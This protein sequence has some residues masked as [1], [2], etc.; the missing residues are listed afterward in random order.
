[1]YQ[2]QPRAWMTASLFT[3]WYDEVFIP[4]VKKHQNASGTKGDVFLLVDNAP[5]HPSVETMPDLK[6]FFS[7]T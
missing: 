6:F 1:M 3:E 5:T 4:A 7:A 2:S